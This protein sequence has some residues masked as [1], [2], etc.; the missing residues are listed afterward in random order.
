MSLLPQPPASVKL[1]VILKIN[2]IK[3]GHRLV[4]NHYS[5]IKQLHSRIC[6]WYEI[7]AKVPT[8]N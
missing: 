2:N 7:N 5:T 4:I 8:S 3:T 6:D 1:D